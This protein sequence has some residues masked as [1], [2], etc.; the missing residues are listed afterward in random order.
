MLRGATDI[1]LALAKPQQT[2]LFSTCRRSWM[3]HSRPVYTLCSPAYLLCNTTRQAS[4]WKGRHELTD[5]N[6]DELRH[7]PGHDRPWCSG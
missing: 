5:N 4:V 1:P 7:A 6:E 3:A 2:Q